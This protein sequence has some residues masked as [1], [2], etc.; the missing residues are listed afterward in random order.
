MLI[1]FNYT[2]TAGHPGVGAVQL[3]NDTTFSEPIDLKAGTTFVD[4]HS[5]SY[6]RWGDYFAIQNMYDSDGTLIPSEVWMSG[7]YGDGPQQNR[8][9]IAQVYSQDTIVPLHPN[10]GILFPNP[11]T[12]GSPLTVQFNLEIEQNIRAE[13]YNSSGQFVQNLAGRKLPV[14][15]AELLIDMNGLAQG[16]Y[17]VRLTGD[18]GFLRVE[19]IIKL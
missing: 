10:G 3:G 13:L 12:D 11:I 2:S 14:G 4:R 6:E 9:Y 7:F 8:T 15:P 17:I 19:K 1:G 16:T 18:D 5:D